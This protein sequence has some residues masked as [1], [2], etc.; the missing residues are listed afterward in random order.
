MCKKT[1]G[2]AWK[3]TPKQQL[4]LDHY[5]TNATAA[6]REAGFK[7]PRQAGTRLLSNVH[8]ARRIAQAQ[9]KR[10]E[11]T[12]VTTDKVVAELAKIAFCNADDYFEWGE[13][14]VRLKDSEDLTRD[15][16]A[17]VGEASETTTKEGGTIRIK[18]HDKLAALEKLGKH[19]SMFIER[20]ELSGFIGQFPEAVNRCTP[21]EKHIIAGFLRNHE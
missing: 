4:F 7:H 9:A 10:S 2:Q 12:Q 13:D 5:T 8:I 15:Q 17:A 3:P 14:G 6:A 16:K 11:R 21:Q 18:L 20:T 1:N 19:L